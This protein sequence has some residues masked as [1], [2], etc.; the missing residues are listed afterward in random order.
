MALIDYPDLDT[1]GLDN[2]RAIDR[3]A[4]EQGRP[5]LLRMMLAYSPPAQEA[6]DGL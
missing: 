3:F 6:M 2:R 4:Q 1:L 5:T